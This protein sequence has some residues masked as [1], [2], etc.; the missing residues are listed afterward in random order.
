MVFCVQIF[1][2]VFIGMSVNNCVVYTV[3]LF[4]D[5]IILKVCSIRFV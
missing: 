5:C 1:I 2:V 4:M 3:I